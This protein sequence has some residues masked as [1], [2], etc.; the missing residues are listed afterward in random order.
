MKGVKKPLFD[1]TKRGIL[2]K[3]SKPI[4]EVYKPPPHQQSVR[5]LLIFNE[6]Y[7]CFN[8]IH[9]QYNNKINLKGELF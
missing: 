4:R 1:L 6:W 5:L 3:T 2:Y 7:K 8:C 9:F